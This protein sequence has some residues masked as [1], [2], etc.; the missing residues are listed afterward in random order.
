MPTSTYNLWY[1]SYCTRAVRRVT[2]H[3]EYLENQSHDGQSEET[4]LHICEQSLSRGASQSAVRRRWLCL[5][6][7][8]PS[9]SKISSLSMAILALGKARSCREPNL[10]VGVLTDL[11]DVMLCQ[12]SLHDSCRMGRCIIIMK[13]ICSLGHCE[14]D[15]HT[16]H[17]V[18]QWRLTASWLAPQ[19]TVTVH[20]CKVRSP[21]TG[22]QVTSRPYCCIRQRKRCWSD[23]SQILSGQGVDL[24]SFLRRCEGH[25]MAMKWTS[26]HFHW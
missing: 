10:A 13:L 2:T 12:K 3:S 24:A 25:A 23:V 22:C 5:C 20:R 14:R 4:L 9:H 8:W 19:E 1:L 21:L 16:V 18:S 17:K 11:G 26:T 7:V 15:G 6:T